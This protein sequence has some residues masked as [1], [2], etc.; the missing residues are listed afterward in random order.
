VPQLER[1]DATD[2][3]QPGDFYFYVLTPGGRRV[4]RVNAAGTAPANGPEVK[5]IRLGGALLTKV[6]E[7]ST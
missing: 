5:L 4:C 6:R 2:L 7:S 3:P 1:S